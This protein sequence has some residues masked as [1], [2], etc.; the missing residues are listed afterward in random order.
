MSAY[1]S[2]LLFRKKFRRSDKCES[3][4]KS[5]TSEIFTFSVNPLGLENLGRSWVTLLRLMIVD[6][7]FVRTAESM[8]ADLVKN[9]SKIMMGNVKLSKLN[10][11]FN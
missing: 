7:N 5:S 2:N 1:I 10:D 11:A 8:K 4:D 3:N 6:G 9:L